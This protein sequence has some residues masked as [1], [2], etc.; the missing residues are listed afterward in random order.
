M[1]QTITT[2]SYFNSADTISQATRI[3]IYIRTCHVKIMVAGYKQNAF[4]RKMGDWHNTPTIYTW[5]VCFL[6]MSFYSPGC[7]SVFVYKYCL[8]DNLF[9]YSPH[10]VVTYTVID[11]LLPIPNGIAI[12]EFEFGKTLPVKTMDGNILFAMLGRFCSLPWR[13]RHNDHDGVSNHQPH[14]C[15]L[16]ENIKTSRHWPLWGEFTG[17]RWIPSKN[18]Q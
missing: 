15:L 2:E 17:D 7:K 18:G 4:P 12:T 9:I 16:K 5:S 13:W 8:S 10:R 1:F 11:L 6:T 14:H 3:C